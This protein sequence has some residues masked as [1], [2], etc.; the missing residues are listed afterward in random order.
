MQFGFDH[1]MPPDGNEIC[2]RCGRF[3][4]QPQNESC[5]HCFAKESGLE[6]CVLCGS[7]NAKPTVKRI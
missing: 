2:S 3:Y 6:G 5:Y 7:G 1:E 4:I